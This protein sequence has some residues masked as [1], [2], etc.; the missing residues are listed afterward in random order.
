[1]TIITILI[2]IIIDLS[3]PSLYYY[4]TVSEPKVG[5]ICRPLRPSSLCQNYFSLHHTADFVWFNH[6]LSELRFWGVLGEGGKSSP[7]RSSIASGRLL[8]ALGASLGLSWRLLG[9]SWRHLSALGATLEPQ[10]RVPGRRKAFRVPSGGAT[11]RD[12]AAN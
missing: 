5:A 2:I 11:Q 4:R 10:P 1:M 6:A 9:R 12:P 3:R 7:Y 8:A